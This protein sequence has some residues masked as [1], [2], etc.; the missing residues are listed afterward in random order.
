MVDDADVRALLERAKELRCLYAVVGTLADRGLAPQDAFRRVLAAIP[1]GWQFPEHT[2]ACIEYLGRSMGTADFAGGRWTMRAPIRIWLRE[3]GSIAVAYRSLPPGHEG[4][5]FLADER[6]LLEAIAAR[7]GEFLEWKQQELGGEPIGARAEHW[8]WRQRFAE[9]LAATVDRERFGIERIYLT[10]S[11]ESGSA[12]PASDIDL[13]IVSKGGPA[14]RRALELWLEGYS[15]CLGQ[16]AHQLTGV[17]VAAGM[18]DVR[19]ADD[20][21]AVERL[22]PPP[23]ELP[24]AT[25]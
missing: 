8:R 5:P 18:L 17:G 22:D 14:E 13:I 24:P 9:A 10:G 25:P 1:A 11:T 3:V 7:L 6:H 23:R 4:E 20:A 19:F 21:S 15:A 16:V 12:G 2:E